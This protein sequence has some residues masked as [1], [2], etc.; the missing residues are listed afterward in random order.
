MAPNGRM[1]EWVKSSATGTGSSIDIKRMYFFAVS[2]QSHNNS[3]FQLLHLAP[4][5]GRVFHRAYFGFFCKFPFYSPFQQPFVTSLYVISFF[6]FIVHCD[7]TLFALTC[8]PHSEGQAITNAWRPTWMCSSR[9]AVHDCARTR[10][11][12]APPP[13]HPPNN[14][15]MFRR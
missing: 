6:Q 13:S 11:T 14:S 1:S 15:F 4:V 7:D 2:G 12:R 10:M 9:M 8:C 3:F 5:I